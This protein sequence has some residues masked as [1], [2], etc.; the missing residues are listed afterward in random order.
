MFGALAKGVKGKVEDVFGGD[1]K[2]KG[3][4]RAGPSVKPS[5]QNKQE[6]QA[7]AEA[8]IKCSR[9]LQFS[10]CLDSQTSADTGVKSFDTGLKSTSGPEG[11]GGACTHALLAVLHKSPSISYG[12]LLKEMRVVLKTKGY[13]QV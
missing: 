13:T 9:V 8:A 11:M 5:Q 10:G 7:K 4:T 1:D 2:K 12:A 3:G 6:Y